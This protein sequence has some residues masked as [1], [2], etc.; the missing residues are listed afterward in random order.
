[1]ILPPVTA[2]EAVNALTPVTTPAST[3]TAPSNT[4]AE[5]SAGVR[6]IAPVLVVIVI[7]LSPT[8]ISSD[9]IELADT[10][11][12]PEPSPVK[13]VAASVPATVTVFTA[14]VNKSVSSV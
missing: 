12:I 7:A 11:V 2:P 1:M 13:V 14:T 6:L 9:L 4:I 3:F 10:P 8:A 5:P